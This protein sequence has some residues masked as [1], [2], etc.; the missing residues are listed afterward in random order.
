MPAAVRWQTFR[1]V[2][3]GEEGT[4]GRAVFRRGTEHRIEGSFRGSATERDAAW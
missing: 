2:T 3:T 4:L 1:A